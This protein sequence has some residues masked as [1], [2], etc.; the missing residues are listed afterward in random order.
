[1]YIRSSETR[2]STT[3]PH[4]NA[5]FCSCCEIFARRLCRLAAVLVSLFVCVGCCCCCT[6]CPSLITRALMLA[7]LH[8]C[9]RSSPPIGALLLLGCSPHTRV[10]SYFFIVSDLLYVSIRSCCALVSNVF[11]FL[12]FSMDWFP[13]LLVF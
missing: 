2:T 7:L 11:S 9:P 3:T 12:Y 1:M 4:R 10:S 8:L 6:P 5:F 13:F